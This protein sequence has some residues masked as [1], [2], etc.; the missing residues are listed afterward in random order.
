[1]VCR[2]G[3]R[4]ETRDGLERVIQTNYLGHF[5]LTNLFK[6]I[7]KIEKMKEKSKRETILYTVYRHA[8][9]KFSFF[10]K[11]LQFKGCSACLLASQRPMQKC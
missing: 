7:E 8:N 1:M 11:N 5:L 9:L 6:V 4:E 3:G 10:K 2:S